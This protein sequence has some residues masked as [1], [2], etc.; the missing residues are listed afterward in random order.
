VLSTSIV[1]G[2]PYA[3]VPEMGS[4][5]IVV[6]DGDRAAAARQAEALAAGLW[7]DRDSFRP[8]LLPVDEAVARAATLP[9]PTCLLD[10]GDN[11]GGGAPADGTRLARAFL[12]LRLRGSF[13][14]LCDAEAAARAAA[15]GVGG[16]V[17]IAVGGR[18]PEW[19]DEPGAGPVAGSWRVAAITDGRFAETRPRHGGATAFDQG[20]TAVLESDRGPVVMVTSRRMPPFSLGQ[21]RHA[22]LDPGTFRVLAAKGVHAPLAAYGEVCTTFLRVNTPGP[23]TAD[24]SRLRYAHRR[25]PLHPFEPDAAW[26][27]TAAPAG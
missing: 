23:T 1:L 8:A 4:A 27:G 19:R 15:A 5:V 14:C 22:G 24:A 9:G 12:E 17:D 18:S 11:V 26:N 13:A 7:R 20:L 21:L 16:R 6:T 2:F 3:D 25:R 10:M